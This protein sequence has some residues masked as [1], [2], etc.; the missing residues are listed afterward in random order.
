MYHL[1]QIEES[2]IIEHGTI[3]KSGIGDYRKASK[4]TRKSTTQPNEKK[5]FTILKTKT[6]CDEKMSEIILDY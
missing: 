3:N 5:K 4:V 1:S 2:N 6:L